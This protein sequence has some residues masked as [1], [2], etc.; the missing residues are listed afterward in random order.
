[1]RFQSARLFIEP[2]DVWV[3]VYWTRTAE[4]G[5]DVYL[6]VVPCLPLRLRWARE[7]EVE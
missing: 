5:L 4:G 7:G 3:G 2:R 6:C 1:M